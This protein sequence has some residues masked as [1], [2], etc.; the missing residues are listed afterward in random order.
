MLARVGFSSYYME[1]SQFYF[2]SDKESKSDHCKLS[3]SSKISKPKI[4]KLARKAGLLKIHNAI[5]DSDE[6]SKMFVIEDILDE[7]TLNVS[8]ESECHENN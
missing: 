2:K 8:F 6:F 4:R 3:P 5:Y 7:R 1:W